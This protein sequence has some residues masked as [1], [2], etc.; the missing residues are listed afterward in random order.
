MTFWYKYKTV[1]VCVC[2]CEYVSLRVCACVCVCAHVRVRACVSVMRD[3][4]IFHLFLEIN[5]NQTAVVVSLVTLVRARGGM[6][7]PPASQ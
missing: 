4:L 1:P 5:E 7:S 2:M 3:A 6:T